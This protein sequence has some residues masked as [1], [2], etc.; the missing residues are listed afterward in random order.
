MST[1]SAG[2]DSTTGKWVISTFE[3]AAPEN[4]NNGMM[5][6]AV[7]NLSSKAQSIGN[8]LNDALAQAKLDVD[9]PVYLA[10]VTSLSANYNMA[11]QLQS[12]LMKSI[13]DTAQSIIRNV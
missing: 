8:E 2:T 13:K 11:R 7:A 1:P 12:N 5:Y 3:E 6:H 4:S 10:E 9:N